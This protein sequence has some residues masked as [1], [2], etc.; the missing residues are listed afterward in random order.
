[1]PAC[2]VWRRLGRYRPASSHRSGPT[3]TTATK[4][5]WGQLIIV[6]LIVLTAVSGA[7]QWVAWR[8][9]CSLLVGAFLHVLYVEADKTLASVAAVF[10]DPRRPIERTPAA[11]TTTPHLGDRPDRFVAS[12]ARELLNT[13]DSE[14]S[15][16]LSTAMRFLVLYR[17]PVVAQGTRRCDWRL[18]GLVEACEPVTLYILVPSSGIVRT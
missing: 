14:R 15:G 4:I 16:V 13:S 17:D 2:S 12:A 8:L 7:T 6:V 10:S 18:A 5:L 9:G 3:A 1:M 11:M